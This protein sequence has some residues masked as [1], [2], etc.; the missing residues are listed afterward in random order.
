M[1]LL[2]DNYDSFVFNLAHY[3]QELGYD[4]LVIRNDAV[5]VEAIY[6]EM[7]PTHVVLSP[8]PCTPDEAGICLDLV[9]SNKANIPI[10]GVCLGH[11]VIGQAFGGTV[12]KAQYPVHGKSTR[13]AHQEKDLFEGLPN[14]LRVG[15][16]HSLIVEKEN[17]PVCLEIQAQSLQG[18]IMAVK[19]KDYPVYG[20]QFH[21]ESI[22]S[23]SGHALLNNF[24]RKNNSFR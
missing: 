20:V 2:I 5:T 15:R 7:N 17:L 21:P 3:V 24:I 12:S 16:Y 1:I 10:L 9:R 11:Q 18:E 8:G 14:P 22:L 19:H 13:I 23:E 6:S 4:T